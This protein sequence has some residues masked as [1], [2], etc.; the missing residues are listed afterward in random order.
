MVFHY[1]MFLFFLEYINIGELS[2]PTYLEAR[3]IRDTSAKKRTSV[4]LKKQYRNL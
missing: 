2:L 1:Y 3:E 4:I